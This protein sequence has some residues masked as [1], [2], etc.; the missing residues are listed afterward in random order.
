MRVLA[1][2][3]STK[4]GFAILDGEP[5]LIPVI[6]SFGVLENEMKVRGFRGEKY[7]WDFMA[8]A[9]RIASSVEDLLVNEK[10]DYFVIEE[11]NS[12]GRASRYSQKI[13]EWLH[14]AILEVLD[15]QDGQVIYINSAEWRRVV[16]AR[17][18]REDKALNAKVSRLK[19]SG[20][21]EALHALGVR[22]KINK[23]HVA[24]RYVNNSFKLD[25]KVKDNDIADAI[26]EG[27]SFFL[28]AAHCDGN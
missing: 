19:K 5:G 11:T 21:K 10:F 14:F 17:L 7:P 4:T 24:L 13:L 18:T 23:K 27:V 26:C 1:L 25:L 9:K 28:G 6:K 22:G 20:D 8:A 15:R 3:V 2:D 16:G 12:G